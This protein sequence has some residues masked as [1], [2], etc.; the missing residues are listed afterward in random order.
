MKALE[1]PNSKEVILLLKETGL[2]ATS[3]EQGL[4]AIRKANFSNKK[5]Y[6]QSFFL[7]SIG[8]ERILKLIIIVNCIIDK[9]RFPENNELKKYGHDLLELFKRVTKDS[10]PTDEFLKKDRL[11]LPIMTCLS[12]FAKGSRYYNLDTLSGNNFGVD[13]MHEW[14]KI[15]TYIKANYCK[16]RIS[17][18]EINIMNS[19]D[20]SSIIRFRDEKDNPIVT[21]TDLILESKI[22]NQ[23]QGYSVLYLYR[24]IDYIITILIDRSSEK[25]MLPYYHD[26]FLLFKN[27]SMTDKEIRQKK[28]W[29]RL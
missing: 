4:T 17:D 9:G 10:K 2:A 27:P 25:N 12:N 14:Y 6:Y 26:F 16:I 5:L 18:S 13:P 23:V 20:N 24:I 28:D 11:Y 1:D 7:L 19:L 8:I 22:A 21:G 15:Q 3:I 29:S